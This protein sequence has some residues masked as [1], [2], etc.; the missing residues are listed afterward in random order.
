LRLYSGSGRVFTWADA[1]TTLTSLQQ[2][3]QAEWSPDDLTQRIIASGALDVISPTDETYAFFHQTFQEYLAGVALARRLLAPDAAQREVAWQFA[4]SRRL[5][6]R[7]TEIMRLLAPILTQEDAANGPALALRWLRALI[8]QRETV[9]GDVGDLGLSLAIATLAEAEGLGDTQTASAE[10]WR[11]LR[12]EVL[13]VWVALMSEAV[14][15]KRFPRQRR[16]KALSDDI[17]RVV[18]QLEQNVAPTF[19]ADMQRLIE[20]LTALLASRDQ[21]V[22][23]Q[24]MEAL[25]PFGA[26]APLP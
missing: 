16:L 9:D 26:Y 21:F 12:F 7:W 11:E 10:S 20:P 23:P 17:G 18:V 24:A 2:E 14:R 5:Y 1:L 3:Q 4:W 13:R 15:A 22:S 6:S 19:E 25:I 8:G